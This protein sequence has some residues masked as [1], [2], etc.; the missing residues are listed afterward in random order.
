MYGKETQTTNVKDETQVYLLAQNH[1]TVVK[2]DEQI[3][4]VSYYANSVN[5]TEKTSSVEENLSGSVEG[6]TPTDISNIKM[7]DFFRAGTDSTTGLVNAQ[8]LIEY[9]DVKAAMAD[10]CNFTGSDFYFSNSY[11]D[12]RVYNVIEV[13]ED[14]NKYM[15]RVTEDGFADGVLPESNEKL[16]TIDNSVVIYRVSDD[17]SKV[18]PYIEGSS[19]ERITP[20]DFGEAK[21]EGMNA[22]KIA[23]YRYTST[24]GNTKNPQMILIYE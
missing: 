17:G 14:N 1:S 18:T 24:P 13:Q 23:I 3:Y 4:E 15:L 8:R 12:L 7:G 11:I 6:Y 9:A 2:D 19:S 22:S 5:A 21:Y 20:L 10:N 16:I